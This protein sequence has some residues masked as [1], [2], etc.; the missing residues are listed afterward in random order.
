MR[1]EKH[2]WLICAAECLQTVFHSRD[3]CFCH[4]LNVIL[5]GCHSLSETYEES[6]IWIVLNEGSDRFI[7]IVVKQWCDRTV[8]VLCSNLVMLCE[9]FRNKN[10][11]EHLYDENT[12][13]VC[14]LCEECEDFLV[15]LEC[16]IVNL[17][18]VRIVW[19]FY[20]RSKR[21]T[22][23]KIYRVHAVFYKHVKIFNPMLLVVEPREEFWC[24]RIFIHHAAWQQI[25]FLN[26][27]TSAAKHH[28]WSIL[29]T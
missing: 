12:T 27:N 21:M 13:T 7:C 16:S 10:I 25:W 17:N 3:N 19:Q 28:L 4:P 8:A 15:L 29:H 24:V 22:V 20:Q 5:M 11:V 26:T 2:W 1:T 9:W 14:L 18:C 6:Y 23:P